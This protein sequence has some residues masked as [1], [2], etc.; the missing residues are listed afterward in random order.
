M[1]TAGTVIWVLLAVLWLMVVTL[2][3]YNVGELDGKNQACHS[4]R[5]AVSDGRLT[6]AT[7][8][9]GPCRLGRDH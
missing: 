7:L 8:D 5:A 3:A 4:L 6:A 1:R 9:G 2:S